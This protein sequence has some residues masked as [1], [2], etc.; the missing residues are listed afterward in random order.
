MP[1]TSSVFFKDEMLGEQ[2]M[3]PD[4]ADH[5]STSQMMSGETI[6]VAEGDQDKKERVSMLLN[7][8]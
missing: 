1:S 3:L 7:V 6:I 2:V 4:Y 8:S 5:P